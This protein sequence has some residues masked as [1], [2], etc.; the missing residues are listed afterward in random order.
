MR[1]SPVLA[2]LALAGSAWA[3]DTIEYTSGSNGAPWTVK[4]YATQG[5][6]NACPTIYP[7]SY[8]M[9]GTGEVGLNLAI[10]WTGIAESVQTA[11]GGTADGC[12]AVATFKE[13]VA[14]L[15][16]PSLGIAPAS[17]KEDFMLSKLVE[18]MY[19]LDPKDG[20]RGKTYKI[21][22]QIWK[23]KGPNGY[24]FSTVT[25]EN[26]AEFT[27]PKWLIFDCRSDA[28]RVDDS[29]LGPSRP[30]EVLLPHGDPG[31]DDTEAQE[32]EPALP[33]ANPMSIVERIFRMLFIPPREA[34]DDLKTALAELTTW[35]PFGWVADW[36]DDLGEAQDIDPH[37]GPVE[38]S[39]SFPTPYG[40]SIMYAHQYEGVIKCIR[41]LVL[42]LFVLRI[43]YPFYT[44]LYARL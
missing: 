4:V 25:R 35:G 36:A 38:Y 24:E 40:E 44:W 22:A 37:L 32:V 29:S 6:S 41:M 15:A 12:G 3:G 18:A 20:P 31:G 17:Y 16:S 28:C 26:M 1:L 2:V 27:W 33:T 9:S 7:F 39:I 42:G 13:P 21:E 10:Y 19:R 34:F 43:C 14:V 11:S 23:G 8:Y 5:V 30:S